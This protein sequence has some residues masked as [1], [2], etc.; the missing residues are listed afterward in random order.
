MPL[1]VKWST[2][3]KSN[4]LAE[5]NSFG[6]YEMADTSGNIMYIGEGKIRERLNSHFVGG[7]DPI[8]RSAKYR[9]EVTG[10]KQRAEERERSELRKYAKTHNGKLPPYNE[11][12]G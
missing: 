3:N 9:K 2:F 1:L 4:V 11:R 6:I 8:G 12:L 5:P 7:E 10:S